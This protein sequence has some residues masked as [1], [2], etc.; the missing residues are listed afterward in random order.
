MISVL[1]HENA[2]VAQQIRNLQL[3]AYQVEAELLQTDRTP[4]LYD[5]T[6][7]IQSCEEA[8]V[9][10]FQGDI[11]AGFIS[12]KREANLVDIHRLVVS[13]NY[14]RQGIAK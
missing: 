4:R 7:D 12:F 9:G 10:L 13:P 2:Q 3:P 8:F 14:S 11:L 5:S 1:N 6:G